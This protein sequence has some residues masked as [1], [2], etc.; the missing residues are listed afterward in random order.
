MDLDLVNAAGE[1]LSHT[2]TP[3][4]AGRR[5]LVIV[6]HGVTSHHDREYLNELAAGLAARGVA[7]LQVTYAGNGQSEGSFGECTISKEIADLG[8]VLDALDGW[9]VGYAGHS[10]G[11]AVGVLR[12]AHDPRIRALCS[13]AGMVRVQQF[14]E[15][16]FGHLSPGD[17]MLDKAQCPLSQLFL[18]DARTIGTTLDAA[19]KVHVPWLLVHGTADELV[20]HSDSEEVCAGNPGARLELLQG[21]D[22]RFAG[23]VASMVELVGSFFDAAL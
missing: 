9:T 14:M 8:S 18:A 10:M 13:L 2:F 3:G 5:A 4:E 1:R 7:A 22:H 16:T 12:A 17:A 19:R 15:R 6:T 21:A 23:H 11:A 20:P